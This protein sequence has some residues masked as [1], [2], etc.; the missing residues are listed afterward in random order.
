MKPMTPASFK[1]GQKF[2]E[3]VREFLFVRNYYDI[4][5]QTDSY[6]TNSK[7]YVESSLKPY[8]KFRDKLTKKEFYIEAKFRTSDY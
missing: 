8:F 7:D 3:Y 4:L 1:M 2:E 6:N 5:E